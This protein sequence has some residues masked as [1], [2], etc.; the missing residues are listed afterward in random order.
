MVNIEE[1]EM[2]DY[3]IIMG[4]TVLLWKCVIFE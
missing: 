3:K 1:Q 2:L 4:A